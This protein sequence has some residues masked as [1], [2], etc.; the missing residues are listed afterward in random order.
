M[1]YNCESCYFHGEKVHLHV[2]VC[3]CMCVCSDFAF[4]SWLPVEHILGEHEETLIGAINI[5]TG[6]FLFEQ[7]SFNK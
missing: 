4:H 2:C 7:V 1:Q 6:R 3:G 5:C